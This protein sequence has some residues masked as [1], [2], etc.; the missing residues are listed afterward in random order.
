MKQHLVVN[1]KKLKSKAFGLYKLYKGYVF[2]R[3]K[4]SLWTEGKDYLSSL[5]VYEW[6]SMRDIYP[7]MVDMFGNFNLIIF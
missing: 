1:E 5:S 3:L 2:Q 4:T 7:L 6:I